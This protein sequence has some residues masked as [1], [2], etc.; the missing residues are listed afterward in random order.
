MIELAVQLPNTQ[1]SACQHTLIKVQMKIQCTSYYLS[2]RTKYFFYRN[3]IL[4]LLLYTQKYQLSILKILG[5]ELQVF[6]QVLC[7]IQSLW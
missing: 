6:N 3:E 4:A 5:V 2:I 1:F 7:S